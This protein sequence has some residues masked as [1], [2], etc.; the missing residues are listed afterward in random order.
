A[1][2]VYNAASGN[3][4]RIDPKTNKLV[5]TIP[6]RSYGG[7]VALGQGAVWVVNA[8]KGE[9][10][11]VDPQTNKVV[12]TIPVGVAMDNVRTLTVGPGTV[13]V[14]DFRGDSLIRL[15]T[16]THQVVATIRN[17]PGITG[18]SFGAGSVWTCNHH[19]DTQ[20]LVRLDPQTN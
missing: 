18:V 11:K 1:I 6:L 10:I 8:S 4:F 17:Q 2:W 14:S 3:L 7:G 13:W 16:H 12:A 9:L 19:S 15:D 5:A 20:G